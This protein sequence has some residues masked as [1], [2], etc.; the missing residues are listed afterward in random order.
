MTRS[1]TWQG[2]PTYRINTHPNVCLIRSRSKKEDGPAATSR[3]PPRLSS[4]WGTRRLANF[5]TWESRKPCWA[6]ASLKIPSLKLSKSTN[7]NS[8]SA[9]AEANNEQQQTARDQQL[10]AGKTPR[11]HPVQQL[12]GVV[13]YQP[14][15]PSLE[16][17]NR[18]IPTSV[19]R[20][21]FSRSNDL[22]TQTS[23]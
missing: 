6:T 10:S 20:R 5:S 19:T 1:D 18:C 13:V 4:R 14:L 22:H 2:L 23:Q 11:P 12:R 9:G 16:V 15:E 8:T 3:D 7:D 17:H 21:Q